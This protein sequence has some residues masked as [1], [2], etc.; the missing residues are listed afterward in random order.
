MGYLVVFNFSTELEIL[1]AILALRFTEKKAFL[2]LF[3]V[4]GMWITVHNLWKSNYSANFY[5][6]KNCSS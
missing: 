1:K 3:G 5:L 6:C 4:N 2:R